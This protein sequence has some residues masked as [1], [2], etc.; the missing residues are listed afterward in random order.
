MKAI[1]IQKPH[2]V[3]LENIPTPTP[4]PEEVVLELVALGLC[5]SDLK[6]YRGENPLITYPRIPGHEFAGKVVNL[7]TEV[8]L[9]VSQQLSIGQLVTISPYTSCGV[10]PACRDGRVNTC[11]FNK[12][13][14]VQQDGAG[15]EQLSIHYSKVFPVQDN[16][17][18]PQLVALTEPIS[19]GYHAVNRAEIKAKEK[20]LIIGCGVIGLGAIIAASY[21]GAAITVMDIDQKKLSLA[22]NFGAISFLDNSTSVPEKEIMDPAGEGF[23]VVIEAVG[24]KTTY[25]QA[26]KLVRVAG[27]IVYIGYINKPAPLTTKYIVSKELDIRGSRNAFNHEIISVLKILSDKK[28]DFSKLI[29]QT[30]PLDKADEAFRYWHEHTSEVTK[31]LL[32]RQ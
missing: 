3:T 20:V 22:K 5:G 23:D 14:G 21:K 18:P 27:R 7:G 6:T 2:I 9:R 26:L 19:V 11:Q 13:L 31:V 28:Y 15:S 17:L 30:Y 24:N 8:P 25:E 12:T 1:K 10:C 32:Y 4:K 29:S 16:S